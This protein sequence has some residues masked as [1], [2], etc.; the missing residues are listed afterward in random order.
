MSTVEGNSDTL[1]DVHGQLLQRGKAEVIW[2]L[3]VVGEAETR[4]RLTFFPNSRTHTYGGCMVPAEA[5]SE[6]EV[7]FCPA[8]RQT[9]SEWRL[10]PELNDDSP[11]LIWD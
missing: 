7:W 4:A 9:E 3:P 10:P 6:V 11:T 8:C 2:G 1:C 5:A